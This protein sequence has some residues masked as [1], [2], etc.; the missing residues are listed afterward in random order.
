MQTHGEFRSDLASAAND[1][2]HVGPAAVPDELPHDSGYSPAP[3]R[4][5]AR[6]DVAASAPASGGGR[7]TDADESDDVDMDALL[8]GVVDEVKQDARIATLW[9]SGRDAMGTSAAGSGAGGGGGGGRWAGAG[10]SEAASGIGTQGV[11]NAGWQF[12]QSMG[13]AWGG[14]D[15]LSS[16]SGNKD[17]Q[18]AFDK[19]RS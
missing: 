7:S 13:S 12:G 6:Q 8:D 9:G 18:A 17:P 2:G 16:S 14:T 10:V 15:F 1:P 5:G 3:P 19:A 4:V 11:T